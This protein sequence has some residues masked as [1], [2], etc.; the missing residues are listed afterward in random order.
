MVSV[1]SIPLFSPL[2]SISNSLDAECSHTSLVLGSAI[3]CLYSIMLPVMGFRM[4]LMYLLVAVYDKGYTLFC[5]G[6]FC[7]D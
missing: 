4:A 6:F 1:P 2:M 7:V 5:L 3:R